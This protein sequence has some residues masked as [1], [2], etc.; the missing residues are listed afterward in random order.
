MTT[1]IAK[2]DKRSLCIFVERL[3]DGSNR[4]LGTGCFFIHRHLV[5]TAKH[6]LENVVREQR[7]IFIANDSNQGRLSGARPE[8][9]FPHPTIDLALVK[10]SEQD[11]NIEH[12]LYPAHFSLNT[13]SG[14]IAIGYNKSLSNNLINDWTLSV[15]SISSFDVQ[16]RERSAGP[17]EYILNFE[18]PWITPGCSGG[19]VITLGGG[20]VAV[21][22]ETFTDECQNTTISIPKIS[23][24]AT[25]IYPIME[26]F[27]SPFD[28]PR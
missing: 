22:T 13:A 2:I 18:A 21:L 5:L 8:L 6:V 4:A 11:L 15:H 26:Y 23:G 16:E 28:L 24:R 17:I 9:F 20:I 10:V 7:Q 27:R 12:P 1:T 14:G 3:A 25:S 19:P